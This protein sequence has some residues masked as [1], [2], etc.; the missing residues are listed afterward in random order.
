MKRNQDAKKSGTETSCEGRGNRQ[1]PSPSPPP[2]AS[3]PFRTEYDFIFSRPCFEFSWNILNSTLTKCL[4]QNNKDGAI[5]SNFSTLHTQVDR[6]VELIIFRFAGPPKKKQRK[7]SCTFS[8]SVASPVTGSF[9]CWLFSGRDFS[10]VWFK[11][12]SHAASLASLRFEVSRHRFQ[13]FWFVGFGRDHYTPDRRC[14][15]GPCTG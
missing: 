10:V 9:S 11:S 1:T 13:R 4:S 6:Q 8:F 5:G 3:L 15:P 14:P 7:G 12:R 2:S